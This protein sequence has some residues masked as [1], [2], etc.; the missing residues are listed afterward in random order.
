MGQLL[1]LSAINNM[2]LVIGNS[3]SGIIETPVLKKPTVNIGLRQQGRIKAR[4]IIDCEENE[5]SIVDAIRK[6]LSPEFN[7]LLKKTDSL[8]GKGGASLKIKDYLKKVPLRN[9]IS[10]KFF[11]INYNAQL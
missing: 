6:A 9:I 7:T 10:K 1:Y 8:Y 5:I 4:S 3:S 2:N 11:D